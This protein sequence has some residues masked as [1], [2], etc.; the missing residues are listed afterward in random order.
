MQEGI[1]AGLDKDKQVKEQI[2]DAKDGIL[3]NAMFEKIIAEKLTDSQVKKYY[4]DHKK[5]FT[6]VKASHILVDGEEQAKNIHNQLKKG[7]DFAELAKKHSK[8]TS[9]KDQGGELGYFTRGQMVKSFEDKAFSLKVN[10]F[11]EPVQTNFGY[12]IIKVLDIKEP[13]KFEEM[14]PEEVNVVKRKMLNDE[15][16]QLKKEAKIVVHKDRIKK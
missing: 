4:S 13:K 6:Q 5:E 7:A 2:Q 3:V 12:H 14:T 16:E 15:I 11:S 9:N 8:D 1:R 10:K